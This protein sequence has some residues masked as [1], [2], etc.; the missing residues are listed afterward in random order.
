[1][2]IACLA[3]GSLLWKTGPLRLA[4]SWKDDGPRLPIEFARVGDKGELS[5]VVWEGCAPQ[6]T[7]WALV[8][9]QDL[10][11]AREMLRQREEIDADRPEWLGS[12]P[13]E[14]TYPCA[15]IIDRWL[16]D[17]KLDAVV[18]TALP[19]RHLGEEGRP[20]TVDEAVLYLDRLEGEVR[21][22][23]EN[24]VR[25]IPASL[26]TH[27]RKAIEARLGWTPYRVE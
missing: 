27:H 9:T 17:R 18:W 14:S 15:D 5:T 21:T 6:K 10:A 12:L 23:A 11:S 3:W 26:A 22:H 4:S 19:A 2:K 7:W 20:P 1:M 25:Q 16:R 13:S 8:D 24:Y